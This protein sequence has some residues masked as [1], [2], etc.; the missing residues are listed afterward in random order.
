MKFVFRHND[1]HR[2]RYQANA[3]SAIGALD[4]SKDWQVEIKP[5]KEPYSELQRGALWGLAYRILA[6]ATGHQPDDLHEYYCGEYWGWIDKEVMGHKFSVPARTTTTG[7]AGERD[8]IS[9]LELADFFTFI[10]ARARMKDI[11]I[12][13]PDPLWKQRMREEAA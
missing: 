5:H 11:A 10:Q 6:D 8:V 2:D 12:P 1:A 13:D 9:K 7:F 3:I 4:P